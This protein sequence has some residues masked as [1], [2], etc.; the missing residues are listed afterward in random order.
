M[1]L[2]ARQQQ[3][4]GGGS[5]SLIASGQASNAGTLF[6]VSLSSLVVGGAS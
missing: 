3:R 5:F 1:V 6:S 4:K 2:L